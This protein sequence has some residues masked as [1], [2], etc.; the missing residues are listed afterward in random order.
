MNTIQTKPLSN[1]LLFIM[2]TAIAATA[3]NLYYNQPLIPSI[4]ESLRLSESVL[5]FIPSAS[6]IGYAMAIFFISPLGDVMNR[7][8]VI[9]NL[10]I[11]LVIALLGVYFAP[12]FGILV[13]A[14]FVVGLGANIT[15]Q[16]L[17]LG[18]SLA[19]PENKGKV[20]ATLMTGLT[21]GILL[22]RTLSGFI[23]EH[24]GWRSVFLT[25][26]V[27]AAIIGVVLHV[28]L[29]SN[30]PTAKL[31]YNQLLASMFTL[32]KTKP[33]L[34]EAAFVGALWFAAFNAM[35]ATIAIH[36]MEEPF[37]LSVQQVGLLGFVGAAGIF[38]AKI[39]GKWADKIGA[40]KV[41]TVSISL[42]LVSFVVLAL[43]QNN[44]VVLCIG[45]VL[46]DLGVFGSQIPNQVRVF[47]VDVNAQ[48][49]ANAIYM[50]FYYIGASAG[51][52]LGVSVISKF[53]WTGLTIFGFAL[54]AIALLFHISKKSK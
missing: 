13:A 48:S 54:A 44:M 1:K 25:A 34:R 30:K 28:Y 53:G 52:A 33:L 37:S 11:T 26:A 31:K 17:P 41:M 15:Q 4:G 36:V 29:P 40:R 45:I 42:V 35:W 49:R 8:T 38:G 3:A 20:V 12:N 7:K 23:A 2:A 51:S 10:S 6:Q 22:S 27:I 21:T 46:L 24:F 14:T 19:T 43:G 39:A 5:G 9:R 18:S 16:L 32:V 50:L 47:S